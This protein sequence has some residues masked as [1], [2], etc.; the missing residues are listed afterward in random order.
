MKATVFAAWKSHIGPVIRHLS[1]FPYWRMSW[2]TQRRSV[3]K[4]GTTGPKSLHAV[5]PGP[6]P[7]RKTVS[8]PRPTS[9]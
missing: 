2:S 5:Q 4:Y 6:P 1:D 3:A 7:C 8:G 9:W